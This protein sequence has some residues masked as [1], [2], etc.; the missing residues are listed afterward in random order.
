[1]VYCTQCGQEN[2]EEANYCL[3]CGF[4]MLLDETNRFDRRV[5]DFADEIE[6]LATEV[7]K[8]AE[9]VAKRIYE[10]VKGAGKKVEAKAKELEGEFQ[11]ES[12]YCMHCGGKLD[13]KNVDNHKCGN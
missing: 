2:V 5:E 6:K 12:R 9:V 10:D 13:D 11:P 4:R 3:K 7:G 8:K 1:M